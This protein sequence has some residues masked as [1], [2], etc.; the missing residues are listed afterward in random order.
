MKLD[1]FEHIIKEIKNNKPEHELIYSFKNKEEEC[2]NSKKKRKIFNEEIKNVRYEDMLGANKEAESF[3]GKLMENSTEEYFLTQ[4]Y[5]IPLVG[6]KITINFS[7]KIRKGIII[8]ESSTTIYFVMQN[9]K[10]KQFIKK[11]TFFK[12][13]ICTKNYLVYAE[14]LKYSRLFQ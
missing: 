13:T 12:L 9:N 2:C 5:K 7:G 14:N 6:L 3:C 4:L 1:G 8:H 11:R 10:I